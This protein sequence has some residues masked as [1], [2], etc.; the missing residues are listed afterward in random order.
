MKSI[1]NNFLLY[2]IYKCIAWFNIIIDIR[3]IETKKNY[4]LKINYTKSNFL[5]FF[6]NLSS[7]F[8]FILFLYLYKDE[9][10]V[11]IL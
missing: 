7:I 10:L 3:Y 6:A 2:N 11:N 4:K 9:I 8:S 1:N 5:D